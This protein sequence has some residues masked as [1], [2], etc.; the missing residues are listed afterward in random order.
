VS[1]VRHYSRR[2]ESASLSYLG[3]PLE[4]HNSDV[5]VRD[6][7][8]RKLA[9]V[10]TFSAAHNFIRGYRREPSLVKAEPVANPAKAT[11]GSDKEKLHAA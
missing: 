1:T 2:G 6:K 10:A 3:F 7:Q 8:G 4:I 9:T 11:T 5:T